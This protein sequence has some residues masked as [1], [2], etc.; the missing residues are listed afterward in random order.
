MIHERFYDIDNNNLILSEMNNIPQADIGKVGVAA[1]LIVIGALIWFILGLMAF[2]MSI[3]CVGQTK[4]KMLNVIGI[5][6]AVFFGPFY[7]FYYFF[8]RSYCRQ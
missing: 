5:L 3:V 4:D 6:L 2:I 1:S 8:V 7:W